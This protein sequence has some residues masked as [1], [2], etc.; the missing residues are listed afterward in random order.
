MFYSSDEKRE[1]LA[2]IRG[3][4]LRTRG[5]AEEQDAAQQSC[6]TAEM[7]GGERKGKSL[8]FFRCSGGFSGYLLIRARTIYSR[9]EERQPLCGKQNKWSSG[10]SRLLFLSGGKHEVSLSHTITDGSHVPKEEQRANL[11]L[12]EGV[13]HSLWDLFSRGHLPSPSAEY[14]GI[15]HMGGNWRGVSQACNTCLQ[16]Q[17][18]TIRLLRQRMVFATAWHASFVV[19]AHEG[20]N[21]GV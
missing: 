13:Q 6:Y 12:E 19:T 4:L 17:H 7:Q 1:Q 5:E 21:S 15:Y 9:K 3:E 8:F 18:P 16:D 20:K 11:G 2:A 10:W 14:R